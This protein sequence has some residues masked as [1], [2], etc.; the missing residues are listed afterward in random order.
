MRLRKVHIL[1]EVKHLDAAEVDIRGDERL[2]RF[3]LGG[4]CGHDDAR[5]AVGGNGC[6]DTLGGQRGSLKPEFN[7]VFAD[8]YV[9]FH[10]S[11]FIPRICP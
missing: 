11:L 5:R 4:A 7:R 9:H 6:A 3:E 1:V 2:K 10:P 8:E